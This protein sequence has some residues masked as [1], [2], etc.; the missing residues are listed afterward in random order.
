MRNVRKLCFSPVWGMEGLGAFLPSTEVSQDEN[1]VQSIVN[2]PQIGGGG[3]G[4]K[5]L[6]L[7]FQLVLNFIGK[8]G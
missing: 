4:I 1:E 8:Q 7:D 3:G 6:F 2:S 5:N